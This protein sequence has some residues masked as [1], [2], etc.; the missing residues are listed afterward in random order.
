MPYYTR[1]SGPLAVL[2]GS[3]G[4]WLLLRDSGLELGRWAQEP[5]GEVGEP[6]GG[7]RSRSKEFAHGG[8]VHGDTLLPEPAVLWGHGLVKGPRMHGPP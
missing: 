8:S 1:V 4:D 7:G 6:E 2:H 5:S 3:R